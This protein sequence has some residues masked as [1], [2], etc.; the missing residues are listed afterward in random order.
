ML[1]KISLILFFLGMNFHLFG[2]VEVLKKNDS[3]DTQGACFLN[4]KPSIQFLSKKKGRVSILDES[5]ELYFSNLQKKEIIAFTGEE[6][7]Q[8]DLSMNRDFAKQKFSSA[9]IEFSKDEQKCISFVIDRV[10]NVLNENSLNLISSHPWKLIK[11]EDWL[12]GGFA[13]TRGDVIILSQK[14][15]DKLTT[16]WSENMT[17]DDED[18]LVKRLGGL[19]LHEQFHCLQRTHKAI[20]DTLYTQ[21]WGFVKVNVVPDSY[22]ST[23]QVSNP[24]APIPEWAFMEG[25][26]YYWVRTLIKEGVI[27]PKMGIDFVDVVFVLNKEENKFELEKD[28]NGKLKTYR[29]SHFEEYVNSFP[30]NR[31]LDHPNEI[32]AYMFSIYFTSLVNEVKPFKDVDEKSLIN[33]NEFI[34]WIKSYLL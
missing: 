29:L 28:E 2:K 18:Q 1:I 30:V 3:F 33:S 21:S 26:Q 20:F 14:Y 15:L 22:I 11:V 34:K 13:H 17:K 27:I 7:P 16:S 32:S 6:P 5:L 31:G 8:G 10:S 19:L 25:D 24:D 4:K 23:N 9:V 12:C